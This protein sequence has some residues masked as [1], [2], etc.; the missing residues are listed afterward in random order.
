M[1]AF[2]GTEALINSLPLTYQ[3]ANGPYIFF[4]NFFDTIPCLSVKM[5]GNL[6][7]RLSHWCNLGPNGAFACQPV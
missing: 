7:Q 2:C 1:T 6:K 4:F 3:S 5:K